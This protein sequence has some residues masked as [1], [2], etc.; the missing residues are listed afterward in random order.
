M[1]ND[2]KLC[3]LIVDSKQTIPEGLNHEE[4]LQGTIYIACVSQIV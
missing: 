4:A 2:W 3:N 1:R